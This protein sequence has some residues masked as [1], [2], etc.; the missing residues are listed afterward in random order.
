MDTSPIILPVFPLT[1]VILLPGQELP[2]NIFEP[3]YLNMV[4]YALEHDGLIGMIQPTPPYDGEQDGTGS[5][6]T[7]GTAG[8]IANHQETEDGRIEL[9][10]DAVG[11]F[12]VEEELPKQEGF[13]LVRAAYDDFYDQDSTKAVE[14]LET[15]AVAFKLKRFLDAMSVRINWQEA[16]QMSGNQ[17]VDLLA[18]MLPFPPED[19][20][21][22]L[23]AK[24]PTDRLDVMG[25]LA[26]MY[27]NSDFLQGNQPLH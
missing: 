3:R 24:T 8:R 14:L 6:F 1:G 9:I 2:L 10:L 26:T 22:L 23:E 17:L 19:K 5:L 4:R 13:R 25:A 16:E 7:I 20:Q 21:A 11:R 18:M 27:A 12:S 15:T